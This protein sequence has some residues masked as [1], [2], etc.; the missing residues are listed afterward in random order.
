MTQQHDDG[1]PEPV[2]S[3]NGDS[4]ICGA[5]PPLDSS[6]RQ[7]AT[8]SPFAGDPATAAPPDPA[9][10]YIPPAGTDRPLFYSYA[11]P[12]VRRPVRIPHFGHLLLLALLLGIAFFFM[13]G[14]LL[15]ATHFR[16]FGW[17]FSTLSATD[18][19]LNLFCEGILYLVAFGLSLFVFP[20]IWN[21]GYFKGL[22][23]HG[24]TAI[25]RFW[26]LAGTAMGCFGLAYL[27]QVVMPG[28]TNAPIEKM[29]S[30]PRAAW[31]MFAFG[32]TMAP[33]FEEMFFRGFLLPALAT[34]ADW[35]AEKFSVNTPVIVGS[36]GRVQWPAGAVAAAAVSLGS[37]PAAIF[38][39]I[40]VKGG[41]FAL[42]ILLS[43]LVVIVLYF[44]VLACRDS[45]SRALARPIDP[46]GQPLWPLSSMV[47][48][49]LV[50][51]IAFAALHLEQQGNSLGPFLLLVVIS[52]V[53]CAVRLFTRSLASSV[54]VHACYNFMLFVLLLIGTGGFRHFDKM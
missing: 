51:S 50:T 13:T 17:K 18:L 8:P 6:E 42:Q 21:E 24:E 20:R 10:T 33:F 40:Y 37:V 48:A 35:I 23:W 4:T 1:T 3:A 46:D 26:L 19:G 5:T 44:T 53:L 54:L 34:A 31:M 22:Q 11:Q 41:H 15:A 27:D 43:Y 25:S 29:I 38:L 49:S 7:A 28:P 52:L 30:S 9:F 14:A 45:S 36:N 12:P 47:V 39:A 2:I 16:L 32:V